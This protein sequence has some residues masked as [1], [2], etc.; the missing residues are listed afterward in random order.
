MGVTQTALSVSEG[1]GSVRVC[2]RILS[3]SAAGRFFLIGFTTIGSSA[4]AGSDFTQE[5]G[6]RTLSQSSVEECV[7]VPIID[8]SIAEPDETFNFQIFDPISNSAVTINPALAV[9]TITDS[10]TFGTKY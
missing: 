8:D 2:M 7:D 1:D 9:I 4:V 5:T 6:T 10:C 3:G